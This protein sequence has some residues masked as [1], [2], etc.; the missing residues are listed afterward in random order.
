MPSANRKT[1]AYKLHVPNEN[2]VC[3]SSIL[4]FY[5][6]PQQ[7]N[8]WA[9]TKSALTKNLGNVNAIKQQTI[10]TEHR[11]NSSS[12]RQWE[13]YTLLYLCLYFF[14]CLRTFYFLNNDVI[15]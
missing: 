14:F 8:S 1:Q 2:Y 15:L 12:Q 5:V 3:D 4:V 7:P 9:T 6:L 11:Q 13:N 10:G